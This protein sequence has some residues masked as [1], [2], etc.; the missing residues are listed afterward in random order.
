MEMDHVNDIDNKKILKEQEIQDELKKNIVH[1]RSIMN[2]LGA[3]LPIEVMCLP[4][5]IEGVLIREGFIRVYDLIGHDLAEIKGLG[6]A[7]IRILESR[8][9]EFFSVT[10]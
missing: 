5:E 8:L 6:K 4:K 1:Y 10:I 2:F 3:N 7:R 9:D